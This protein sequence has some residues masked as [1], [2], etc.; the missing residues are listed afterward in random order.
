MRRFAGDQQLDWRFRVLGDAQAC[1]E[2]PASVRAFLR[3]RRRWFGGFL[4]THWWYRGMVGD[5][6]FGRLGTVMLPV[7]AIDTVAPLYGL[8]AFGLLIYFLATRHVAVLAPV[9]VVI[10]GKIA[11]D[12]AFGVWALRHY[13]RWVGDPGRASLPAAAAALVLE[14]LTFT[15]LLHAGAVLGWLAFLGG[16]TQRGK[17][18]LP[19]RHVRW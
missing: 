8:T 14:P 3:Q 15:L 6:R 9:L 7:K 18:G 16:Q 10:V 11:I 2:A 12:M 19:L 13:R 4:Q 1:T 17:D 5:P